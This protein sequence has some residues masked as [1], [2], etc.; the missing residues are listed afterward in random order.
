MDNT[1]YDVYRKSLEDLERQQELIKT[2][3]I[4]ERRHQEMLNAQTASNQIAEEANKLA[5][6]SNR[7]AE[8]ACKKSRRANI[9]AGITSL[10]ALAS[11]IVA[12][13]AICI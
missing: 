2:E 12:I 7:I 8:E 3:R 1:G 9:I 13:V 11:L 6:E 10:I 5:L 4:A